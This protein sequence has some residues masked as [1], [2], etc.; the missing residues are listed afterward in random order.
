MCVDDRFRL[1]SFATASSYV[2]ADSKLFQNQKPT[3]C[4]I[5]RVSALLCRTNNMNVGF[6]LEPFS[7]AGPVFQLLTWQ[8][9][10]KSEKQ[11]NSSFAEFLHLHE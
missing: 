6:S 3:I 11:T 8:S 10:S 5:E 2:L 1:V 4:E 9:E 7:K